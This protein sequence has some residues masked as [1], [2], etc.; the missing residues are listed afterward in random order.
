MKVK[1]LLKFLPLVITLLLVTPFYLPR[2]TTW[3]GYV[4]PNAIPSNKQVWN[5][6]DIIDKKAF[7]TFEE[8][9]IWGREHVS[10]YYEC[11]A[12]K[13]KYFVFRPRP[14]QKIDNPYQD[15]LDTLE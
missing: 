7:E 2:I 13:F 4:F 6:K 5:D 14:K 3:T 15:Y 10:Y 9:A 8:C 12:D 1:I 11:D